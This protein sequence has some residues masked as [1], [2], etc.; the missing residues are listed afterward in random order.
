VKIIESRGTGP[1]SYRNALV[2]LAADR[3]RLEELQKAV[4]QFL[5]WRSINE[6]KETLNLDEFQRKQASTQRKTSDQTVVGR[7]PETYRLLLSP[8]QSKS[9]G[10]EWQEVPLQGQ[11]GLAARAFRKMRTEELLIRDYGGVRLRHDLDR[12]SLWRGADHVQVKQLVEDY[13]RYLY[14]PRLRDADTV[15]GAIRD[16]A[17][18]LSWNPETFA[19][20]DRFDARTGRYIGLTA[21]KLASPRLDSEAVVVKPEVAARQLAADASSSSAEYPSGVPP[22][23]PQANGASAGTSLT[24]TEPARPT[25]FYGSTTL[26]PTRLGRDAGKIAEEIVQHL[27]TLPG[28]DVTLTLEIR[29]DVPNGTPDHIVRTVTE[30]CRTLKFRDFGFEEK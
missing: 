23:S 3:P 28:S 22:E 26:D 17:E 24:P 16:G 8:G 1:R 19:Y 4:R 14:L 18:S 11:E 21:G 5:A 13:F 2:F 12:I 15:L 6:E 20:A 27:T 30:N 9:N 7:I 10:T 25:R 29:A